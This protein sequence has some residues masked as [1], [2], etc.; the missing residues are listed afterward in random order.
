MKRLI[1]VSMMLISGLVHA[2]SVAVPPVPVAVAVP[3]VP[4]ATQSSSN[5]TSK[6]GDDSIS[7]ANVHHI[8]LDTTDVDGGGNWLNKRIWYERSQAVF[9]EIRVMVSAVNDLRLQFSNEVNAVGKKLDSFWEVV[10]FTKAELDDKFKEILVRLDTEQKII[11]DLSLDE[12]NLQAAIKQ[13]L[14]L[15]DQLGK[16]IKTIHDIDD[17][18]IDPTLIQ[19][20]K[21]I[22]ECRDYETKAWDSFKA[23]AKELDDK[24]ARNLYYQMN[25]YKQNIDQKSSYLKSTLLPYLHNV[26]VAKV[27]M[28]ITKVNEAI[29]VLKK[30]GIDLEQIMSKS[31]EEDIAQLHAREKIAADIAVR[32]ALDE[33]NAKSKEAAEKAAKSLEKAE[34]K[35]F[36]NVVHRYYEATIGKIVAFFHEGF[37]GTAIDAAG[38]RV[39]SYSYPIARFVYDGFVSLKVYMHDFMQYIM[40]LFG[41]KP[42]KINVV[43]TESK[44]HVVDASEE[45]AIE[46]NDENHED[47]ALHQD[48]EKSKDVSSEPVHALQDASVITPSVAS[49][50]KNVAVQSI[51][52]NHDEKPQDTHSF[53]RVFTTII[54]LICTIIVSIYNCVL[55]FFKLLMSF[56]AY[57][58]SGN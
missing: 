4:A 13:E 10:D 32:K 14:P 6:S 26:L 35:S 33:A 3:P 42:K 23:I 48:V 38:N 37:F 16:D 51:E 45:K 55:Q 17:N 39:A 56:S 29:E 24:K 44:G 9:D 46:K 36:D 25:N 43:K 22:D 50:D 28:N 20:N 52:N 15:I 41:N 2:E 18:K 19:A 30:K 34:A 49:V 21:T 57:I 1:M 40:S 31:Q 47:V 54:D 27:E 7:I 53:Y 11:G 5:T 58:M 12:R 8:S